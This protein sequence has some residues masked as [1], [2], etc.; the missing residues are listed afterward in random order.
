LPGVVA[1][2]HRLGRGENQWMRVKYRMAGVAV[3]TR[4]PSSHIDKSAMRGRFVLLG[5]RRA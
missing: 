3:L 1:K 2:E 4:A 5:R